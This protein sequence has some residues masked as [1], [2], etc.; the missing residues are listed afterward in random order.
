VDPGA[1]WCGGFQ[2]IH[3]AAAMP[4]MPVLKLRADDGD[5]GGQEPNLQAGRTEGKGGEWMAGRRR[6]DIRVA[7][8]QRGLLLCRD[9]VCASVI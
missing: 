5:A 4:D 7:G 3:L 1:A 6:G 2:G 9:R 8:G